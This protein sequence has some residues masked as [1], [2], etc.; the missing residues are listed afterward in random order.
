P[1]PPELRGAVLRAYF[2]G[3]F[4]VGGAGYVDNV[5]GYDIKSA[6]PSIQQHLP[7]LACG[8][9]WAGTRTYDAAAPWAL[10]HV[11]WSIPR[12]SIWAPFPWRFN[13]S[14][15]Y[16]GRGEGWYHASEVAAALRLYPTCLDVLE[17]FVMS[18]GC[19]HRPF[20]WIPSVYERRRELEQA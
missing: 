11:Q 1:E 14:I 18:P 16:L 4:D 8:V 9:T 2:G 10:W 13:Q 20:D 19:D 6:Y 5:Y 3:R 17:G 12:G 15:Y 7:C